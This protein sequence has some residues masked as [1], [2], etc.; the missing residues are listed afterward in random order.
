[1]RG[2]HG[3]DVQSKNLRVCMSVWGVGGGGGY[4]IKAW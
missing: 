2:G 4:F 1:M 3:G